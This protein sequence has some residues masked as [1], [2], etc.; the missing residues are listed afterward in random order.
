MND[1]I[2]IN[3]TPLRSKL[4]S[5]RVTWIKT[6]REGVKSE[7]SDALKPNKLGYSY[8]D[9]KCSG[10]GVC[11]LGVSKPAVLLFSLFQVRASLRTDMFA[12]PAAVSNWQTETYMG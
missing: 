9:S 7:C 2:A 10:T 5:R 6:K 3:C 11:D 1:G 4:L 12:L 8:K